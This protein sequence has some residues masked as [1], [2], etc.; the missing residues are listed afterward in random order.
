MTQQPETPE[1]KPIG[2]VTHYFG[3][4]GVMAVDLSDNLSVGETIHIKGHTTDFI[5]T[6]GSMQIEHQ[7]VAKAGPGDSIGIR[8][9]EKVRPGDTV[10]RAQ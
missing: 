9:G 3:K 7:T 10:Y 1:E 8:V 4:I 5:V 6:V 2:E